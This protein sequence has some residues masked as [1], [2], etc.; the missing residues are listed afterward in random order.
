MFGV[1]G[2]TGPWLAILAIIAILAWLAAIVLFRSNALMTGWIAQFI[3]V[4]PVVTL[5]VTWLTTLSEAD[6]YEWGPFPVIVAA[7]LVLVTVAPG[8]NELDL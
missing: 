2:I 4:V 8:M 1:F 5:M 7:I 6:W 3:A